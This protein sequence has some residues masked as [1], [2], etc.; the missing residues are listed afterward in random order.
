MIWGL[1]AEF[2]TSAELLAAARR[3]YASG[4]RHIEGYSPLPIPELAQS[5]GFRKNYVPLACLTGG[6]TWVGR[7]STC[8][9]IGSV[10]SRI[11]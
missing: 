9:N 4:Y 6:G 5:L 1:I 8:C 11:R 2:E 3:T 10:C 7:V